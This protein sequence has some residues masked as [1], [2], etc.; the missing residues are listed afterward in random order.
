[1]TNLR[2]QSIDDNGNN[3]RP[4]VSI[5]MNFTKPTENKPSLLSFDEVE[6]FLHEFGHA[7]QG[8][9]ANTR[10]ASLSGTNVYRDYVELPSQFNENFL[11]HKE[12]LDTFAKHYETGETIPQELIDKVIASSQYAAGYLCVRQLNFGYLD[13]AYHT[14]TKPIEDVAAFEANAIKMWRNCLMSMV[15]SFLRHSPTYSPEVMLPDIT[16]TSGRKFLKLMLLPNLNK[17]AYSTLKLQ[18]HSRTISSAP[19]ELNILKSFTNASEAET[20]QSMLCCTETA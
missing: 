17:M 5:T 3:I 6:T 2:E 20:P 15:A 12:F 7:L 18:N 14:I 4:I 19:V 1:M 16:A 11:L 9:L 13:M 10:Y 8:L